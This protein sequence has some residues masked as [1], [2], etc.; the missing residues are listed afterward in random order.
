MKILLANAWHDKNIGDS[1]LVLSALALL[2][3][4]YPNAAITVLSMI[5]DNHPFFSSAHNTI[6]S[7]HPYVKL[8]S[9]PLPM[10]FAD[11]ELKHIWR[12]LVFFISVFIPGLLRF[13]CFH[14]IVK[15]HDLVVGV[16]GHYLFTINENTKSLFRLLRLTEVFS[17]AAQK[18]I[19]VCLF[20]QSL[21][22]YKGRLANKV[23]KR[24]FASCR[25]IVREQLSMD[26]VNSLVI[27]ADV[28][29]K[30]DSAF[31]FSESEQESIDFDEYGKYCVLTLREPM[32]GD[33][34]RVRKDYLATMK[35]VAS[36]LLQ[37]KRVD[38]VIIFPHV[39]G[40]T[41]LE[42]DQQI[43]RQLHHQCDNPDIIFLDGPVDID[44]S[45]VLYRKAE[46]TIGTRFHSVVFA[47]CQNTPSV[48]I[49]YFGPKAQ[50]IMQYIGMA[51]LCLDINGFSVD[52]MLL[53]LDSALSD[54]NRSALPAINR[55]LTKELTQID[56]YDA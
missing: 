9:S 30:P 48:A 11:I 52:D 36:T 6:R 38:K 53:K 41:Q 5:P 3:R 55:K 37:Q 22:P 50:G 51:D 2:K 21:G 17:V 19:P 35:E 18:S 46:F 23:M 8:V 7:K 44:R 40:P 33:I 14:K 16:G 49:A 54:V 32:K 12:L 20:S 25:I 56:F 1:A 42:D 43:C 15:Q 26:I 4:K 34:E 47:L 45:L 10:A 13:S 29:V 28:H 24:L 39:K 31:Y 27:N